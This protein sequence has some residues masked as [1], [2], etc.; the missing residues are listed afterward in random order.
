MDQVFINLMTSLG[1]FAPCAAFGFYVYRDQSKALREERERNA[2]AFDC[3]VE[4][5]RNSDKTNAELA[6]A[7]RGAH[8]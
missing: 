1:A 8:P 2:K 4:L 7:L 5:A 3:V 6:A